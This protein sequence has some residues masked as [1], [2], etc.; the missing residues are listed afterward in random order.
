MHRVIL[1][2]VAAPLI[3]SLQ[4]LLRVRPDKRLAH[5]LIE[6]LKQHVSQRR[7]DHASKAEIEEWV[8]TPRGGWIRCIRESVRDVVEWS[9][10]VGPNPPPKY[11][12]KVI[13]EACR[14]LGG[15]EVLDALIA[16]LKD[17][18]AKGTGAQALDV[19]V[20]II[21]APKATQPQYALSLRD[22][23]QVS[24]LDTATLL[25]KPFLDAEALIRLHRRVEAQLAAPQMA[26]MTLP[27]PVP[28][29]ATDQMMHELGLTDAGGVPGV[30]VSLSM[31]QINDLGQAT[32]AASSNTDFDAAMSS[33]TVDL[34]GTI[35]QNLA[36]FAT[37]SD[38]IQMDQG[39]FG[40]LGMT[41]DQ[42]QQPMS[43]SGGD[44][45]LAGADSGQLN[46]EE[47]IFAD[48]MGDLG[49]DFAF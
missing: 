30:A 2:M 21:S 47:D 7:T 18:T 10:S 38:A 49:D 27:L 28:D 37:S 24:V 22:E 29:Q 35:K 14:T 4:D 16:E 26:Q 42:S 12:H 8:A 9:S 11:T 48:L 6:L 33:A 19:C 23:L 15:K 36:N 45:M 41:M 31:D 46:Q 34:T 13:N 3:S 5:S 32:V 43:L 44:S 17:H 25:T 20:A 40:D 1:A 39:V